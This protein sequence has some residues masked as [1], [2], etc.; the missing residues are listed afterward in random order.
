MVIFDRGIPPNAVLLS[1]VDTFSEH[2]P[3]LSQKV[4]IAVAVVLAQLG[5]Q[6]DSSLLSMVVGHLAE[7]VMG[8]VGIL[9]MVEDTKKWPSET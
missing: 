5:L 6:V 1:H 3:R 8:N 9:N 4:V 7:Q 2:V